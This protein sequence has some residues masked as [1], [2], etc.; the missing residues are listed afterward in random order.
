M[1]VKG[2]DGV[3]SDSF[4]ELVQSFHPCFHKLLRKAVHHALH[5]EL[6]W[7]RLDTKRGGGGGKRRQENINE[8][9]LIRKAELEMLS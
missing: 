1:W 2:E 7:Q 3:V 6:L 5:H 9:F 8:A 4:Q